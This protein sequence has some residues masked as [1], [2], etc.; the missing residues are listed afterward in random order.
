MSEIQSKRANGFCAQEDV[1]FLK[2]ADSKRPRFCTRVRCPV[3]KPRGSQYLWQYDPH[4][5]C[6]VSSYKSLRY[7]TQRQCSH[8]KGSLLPTHWEV[9]ISLLNLYNQVARLMR[10]YV[11]VGN[12]FCSLIYF[13]IGNKLKLQAD[14]LDI[15]ILFC[16]PIKNKFSLYYFFTWATLH[17]SFD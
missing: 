16:L 10:F 4:N 3:S 9:T 13:E 1:I 6:G 2:A 7:V 8:T 11:F 12:T 14:S 5:G 17:Y 15:K